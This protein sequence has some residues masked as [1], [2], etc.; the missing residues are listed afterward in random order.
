MIETEEPGNA[1]EQSLTVGRA[2]SQKAPNGSELTCLSYW[3]VTQHVVTQ[4][5][6]THRG[7]SSAPSL[8]DLLE[9]LFWNLSDFI[10]AAEQTGGGAHPP[11]SFSRFG[12]DNGFVFFPGTAKN[13]QT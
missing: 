1:S 7:V 6:P 10:P 12:S 5:Q 9:E 4:E 3:V 2:V 8:W 13:L 11:G